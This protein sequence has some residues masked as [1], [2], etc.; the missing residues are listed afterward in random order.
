MTSLL[1]WKPSLTIHFPKD[2]KITENLLLSAS[3]LLWSFTECWLT[4]WIGYT[5]GGSQKGHVFNW[6]TSILLTIFVRTRFFDERIIVKGEL[7][8]Q[9]KSGDIFKSSQQN[10]IFVVENIHNNISMLNIFLMDL[11]PQRGSFIKFARMCKHF[12]LLW[13][14]STFWTSTSINNISTLSLVHI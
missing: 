12:F 5:L 10:A 13:S 4:G 1:W 7:Y 3:L 9:K 14:T 6:K 8:C 2:T 11:E